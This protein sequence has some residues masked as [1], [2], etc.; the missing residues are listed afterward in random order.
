MFKCQLNHA[1][2]NKCMIQHKINDKKELVYHFPLMLEIDINFKHYRMSKFEFT[3]H[4]MCFTC[5][6]KLG[7]QIY[8][9]F[10]H[11]CILNK[12]KI[13][14]IS[15]FKS[16]VSEKLTLLIL[17]IVNANKTQC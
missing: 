3:H 11:G 9:S 17:C 6:Y 16:K 7:T 1:L 2:L 12:Q 4:T 13:K 14:Q 15:S 5:I 10:L 8:V